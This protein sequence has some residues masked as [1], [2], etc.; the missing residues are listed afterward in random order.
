MSEAPSW[1]ESLFRKN[2]TQEPTRPR[3]NSVSS[4][5]L[6]TGDT[7]TRFRQFFN[8]SDLVALTNTRDSVTSFG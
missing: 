7:W 1:L 8:L 3:S 5:T 6:P 4:T 2:Q